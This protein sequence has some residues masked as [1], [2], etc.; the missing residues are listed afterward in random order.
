MCEARLAESVC[1]VGVDFF[2]PLERMEGFNE[3]ILTRR[4]RTPEGIGCRAPVVWI[5]YLTKYFNCFPCFLNTLNC[6]SPSGDQLI[7]MSR[8][9]N[10]LFVT[11]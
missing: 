2:T 9:G 1:V 8:N 10:F 4:F 3:L 7:F 5:L 6:K 11:I